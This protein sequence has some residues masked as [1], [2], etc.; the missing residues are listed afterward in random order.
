MR[1]LYLN[2]AFITDSKS[3]IFQ[4]ERRWYNPNQDIENAVIVVDYDY[5]PWP[6]YN[7][8]LLWQ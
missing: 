1:E 4:V 8:N 5:T 7:G 3:V 6:R 2:V